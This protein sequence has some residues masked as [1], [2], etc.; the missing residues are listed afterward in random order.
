MLCKH[1]LLFKVT[2]VMRIYTFIAITIMT[3]TLFPSVTWANT[4]EE[5]AG[6]MATLFRSAR[7]VISKHQDHINDPALGDKGLSADVVIKETKE[8]Y[9]SSTGRDLVI[10][11]ETKAGQYLQAELDAIRAVM[12]ESQ[13]LINEKDKGF[14]GFLP[15]VFGGQVATKTTEVL[16]GK[17]EIKLTAPKNYV[18]NRKNRP[19]S[20]EDNVIET[21]FKAPDYTK[22]KTFSEMANKDGKQAFRFI[23]PEYYKEGCLNCH[24]DPKGETDIS[25]GK[26]EGGKLGELGGAISITIYK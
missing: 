4:D 1:L 26:K 5:I 24:G 16:A 17:A 13:T 21:M 15:A 11:P 9:K 19:D 18:R 25:G 23:L 12:D 20:W 10:D 2:H 6:D 8:N 22:D 3:G 7:A 14:K